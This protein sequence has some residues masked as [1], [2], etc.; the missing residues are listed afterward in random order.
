MWFFYINGQ[1]IKTNGNFATQ[2]N[3]ETDLCEKQKT[4]NCL[5][6]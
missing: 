2:K 3:Q 1:M 4:P 6:F 5:G